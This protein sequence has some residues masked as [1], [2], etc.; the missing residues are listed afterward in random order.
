MAFV[1]SNKACSARSIKIAAACLLAVATT[2]STSA[3]EMTAKSL[4]GA[5]IYC[6]DILDVVWIVRPTSYLRRVELNIFT[7][8]NVFQCQER[9]VD[10]VTGPTRVGS[11]G[12][13]GVL[14]NITNDAGH[15]A[16]QQVR[17]TDHEIVW[18]AI[19]K[20]MTESGRITLPALVFTY[21]V[22]VEGRRP[23][24]ARSQCNTQSPR[25]VPSDAQQLCSAN[26]TGLTPYRTS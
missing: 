2:A 12:L 8:N 11:C 19:G 4:D 6:P 18:K 9:Y 15:V 17:I 10:G 14:D 21:T 25:N 5:S 16:S 22:A 26:D 20:G 3:G 24:V 1:L 7:K 23:D 13:F